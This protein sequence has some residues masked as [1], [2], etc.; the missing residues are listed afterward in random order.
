MAAPA[1]RAHRRAGAAP[2]GRSRPTTPTACCARRRLPRRARR[3]RPPIAPAA[4]G[5]RRRAPADDRAACPT[6]AGA[7]AREAAIAAAR[8][9]LIVELRGS[10]RVVA[11][12][13]GAG[14]ARSRPGMTVPSL[15]AGRQPRRREARAMTRSTSWPRACP[16]PCS[17]ATATSTIT[18]V[19][20]DSR[21][22][23]PGALFVAIRGLATDGNQFVDAAR[24]EGRGRDRLRA[25]ARSRAA[26]W[27]QVPDAREALAALLRRRARRPRAS[28]LELVGVTGTNGKTTTTYL[29]DAALRAAGHTVGPAGH[30]PVPHRRPPGRGGAH[31]ARGLRPAGAL[32]RDGGRRLHA[33]PCSRSPRTRWR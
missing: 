17:P 33:T 24:Q 20:Y 14:H 4:A 23:G 16:A 28:A 5:R 2:A 31:H 32:P 15:D 29:I 22:A 18:D 1:L 6:C 8:R 7:S 26:P 25:A 30:R 12:S 19:T 13:P 11:Q 10:G 21:R 27:M 3:A 9:G